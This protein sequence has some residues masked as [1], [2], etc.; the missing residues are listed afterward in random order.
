MSKQTEDI[1]SRMDEKLAPLSREVEN[2]KLEN[3]EMRIKITSLEKMR[4]SNNIILHGI[5]E[6]EASELQLMKMTTKQI[7]TD[8][9]ISLDIRDIN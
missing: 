2:L 4:R 7:N 6:T 1:I 8:L 3:K 9:N 5:E